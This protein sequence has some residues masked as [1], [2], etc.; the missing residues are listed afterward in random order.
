MRRD[1]TSALSLLIGIAGAALFFAHLLVPGRVLVDR[2]IPFLH[3][4]FL[5]S[6][7]RLAG[8]GLPHWNP[9]IH[10]G[11]PLLSNPHYAAFYPPTWLALL[12]PAPLAINLLIVAHASWAFLGTWKLVR[13][14]GGEPAAAALAALAFV[15]G[16]AFSS[17]PNMLNLFIALA[18]LPWVM[19]WSDAALHDEPPRAWRRSAVWL[20]MALAAQLLAGAPVIP[21]LSVLAM[22]C[23]ALEVLPTRPLRVLRLAAA[24]LL[25][26]ALAGAQLIPTARHLAESPRAAGLA[27]EHATTWS[28]PMR[29]LAEWIWPHLHGDPM[30][31]ESHLYFGFAKADRLVPL[32]LSIHG[33]FLVL[34]L[35]LGVVAGWK[36]PRRRALLAMVLIGIFLALG[37]FNPL[38]PQLVPRLPVLNLIRYPEKFLLLSTTGLALLGALG[39]NSV[40]ERWRAG[41]PLQ[42][43][44]PRLAALL[45][46]IASAVLFVLPFAAPDVV[47]DLIEGNSSEFM[48]WADGEEMVGELPARIFRA[49]AGYLGREVL[50]ALGLWLGTLLILELH[51]RRRLALAALVPAALALVALDLWYF[52]RHQNLTAA[53]SELLDP[54]ANLQPLTPAAGRVFSDAVLFGDKI[55][56]L[57]EPSAA[58]PPSLRAALQRLDPYT[59]NL[60]G[61]GYA[62]NEDTDLM[63]TRWARHALRTFHLE[64]G[65]AQHGWNERVYR[66]LGAWNIGVVVRRRSPEALLE[67]QRRTGASPTP[68]RLVRNP[69]LLPRY[70]LVRRVDFQPD[71]AAA[72][73]RV[74]ASDFHLQETEAAV[75]TGRGDRSGA[76]SFSD[77]AKILSLDERPASLSL[78]YEASAAGFLVAAITFDRDWRAWIDGGVA[79][80][81]PTAIGQIGVELPAGRHRLELRF[82]DPSILPAVAVSLLALVAC[83]VACRPRRMPSGD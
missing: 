53:A 69:L 48:E 65:L 15:G 46:V 30:L 61:F 19:R 57:P 62:L 21:I 9:L 73:E 74:A 25:A 33:G 38:Y 52:G 42:L 11:Q 10:G 82:R 23:L 58:V 50:I 66:Y 18:W 56:V 40:L 78:D 8:D 54:P 31:T 63:L 36:V 20:A 45:A 13:R 1:L 39:W 35:A 55:F 72:V 47:V 79:P 67:E 41:R 71:L 70:R 7:S 28:T 51:N 83:A 24:G 75:S 77:Q 32:I 43:A 81:Y 29:R 14:W 59:A 27:V 26:L 16:G 6:F 80:L 22:A 37:R 68:V 49:R 5:D 64:S 34:A 3:L 2:D 12:L 76:V 44:I 17:S 4:P 60:W